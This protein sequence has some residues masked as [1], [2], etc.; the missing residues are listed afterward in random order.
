MLKDEAEREPFWTSNPV[1]YAFEP[2][3]RWR[4]ERPILTGERGGAASPDRNGSGKNVGNI[5]H[6]CN[7]STMPTAVDNSAF[8]FHFPH[9]L[10]SQNN[11]DWSKDKKD[12]GGAASWRQWQTT[13]LMF[14]GVVIKTCSYFIIAY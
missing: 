3:T 13:R 2:L 9:R 8:Y 6:A 7:R 14:V 12:R 5:S 1:A 4:V 11:A 10:M